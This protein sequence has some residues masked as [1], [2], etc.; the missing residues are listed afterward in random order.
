MRFDRKLVETLLAQ[1]EHPG[2]YLGNERAA[3]H[4]DPGTVRLRFALAF[5]EKSMRSPSPTSASISST[6]S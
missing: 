5:P 4:K 6:T 1:V 3:I 2:R